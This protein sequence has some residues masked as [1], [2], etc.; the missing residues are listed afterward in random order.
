[1]KKLI[2]GFLLIVIILV[3]LNGQASQYIRKNA[4]SEAAKEDVKALAVALDK[5]RELQCGD[6]LSWYSQGATHSIP[7][8][9]NS[10]PLCPSYTKKS[11]LK[12]GWDTCTHK[13]GS[14]IHFLIWHRL[15]IAHFEKIVRKLSGKADFALP[16]WNYIN[17]DNRVIPNDFRDDGNSLFEM[18]RLPS[19][20]NGS[21]IESFM[22]NNLNINNLMKNK[23]YAVFNNN[24]DT[25]PHG[26]M[27]GYIGGAY[28]GKQMWN[29]IYQNKEQ[30][31]AS[32]GFDPI[33]WLHHSNID[34]LWQAW[35]LSP[36]GK[37]PTLE[38][39]EAAPWPY[40]FY[41]ENGNK[42]EYTIKEAYEAVFNI[43]YKYDQL[44][45]EIQSFSTGTHKM[46]VAQSVS[47][48]KSLVWQQEVGKP[49][50]DNVLIIDAPAIPNNKNMELMLLDRP[51]ALVIE[52]EVTFSGQPKDAY[53]VFI[54]DGNGSKT[55]TGVMTFFGA[56]HHMKGHEEGHVIGSKTFT[57]DVSSE[58]PADG[59]YDVVVESQT[60]KGEELTVKSMSLYRY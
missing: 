18:A 36:N 7:D 27:H 12:W 2:S 55:L 37:R 9:I 41:D 23:V 8:R 3:S 29:P 43:D 16:Y 21:K 6:P 51:Q 4:S 15:Y 40:R 10:N 20:N 47:Q 13:D 32:A 53:N 46:L 54:V 60:N 39:L 56:A 1:M 24:I 42:V 48:E 59:D 5:M 17:S 35:E 28:E 31:V 19:L 52:L 25:A 57:Y 30:Y 26:A 45:S 14:E 44:Q 11:D 22:D 34:F 33:F 58:L 50:K 49:T 38:V